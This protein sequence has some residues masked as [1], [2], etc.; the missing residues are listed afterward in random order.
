MPT[1]DRLR[2]HPKDRL[3]SPVQ[4]ISFVDAAATLRAEPHAAVSGHRQVALVRH[5]PVTVILF[6][7]ERDGALK[8]HQTEGEV[9][10]QVLAGR[11]AV[12]VGEER[13]DLGPGELVSLAPGQRHAV[14]ALEPSEMLL[15]V[16]LVPGER[17][18][19]V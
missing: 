11:L 7:F 1:E 9:T 2:P 14:R 12:S 4:R 13:L 18:A 15:T 17:T 10:I 8:E 16:C 5:G 19:P 3:A 6:V